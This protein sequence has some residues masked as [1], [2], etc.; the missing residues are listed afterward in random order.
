MQSPD[1]S[2]KHFREVIPRL[3]GNEGGNHLHQIKM[4]INNYALTFCTLAV[5]SGWNECSLLTTYQQG[6]APALRLYLGAYDDTVV[7]NDTNSIHVP[8]S[9][10]SLPWQ[11]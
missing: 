11:K 9:P 7:S 8:S 6:L 4:S 1:S 2:T 5:S 3:V 10:E